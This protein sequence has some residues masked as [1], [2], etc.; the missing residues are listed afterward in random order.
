MD[1]FELLTEEQKRYILYLIE[2]FI[3]EN[4]PTS[5]PNSSERKE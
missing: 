3:K 5:G 2:V 1:K 4:G